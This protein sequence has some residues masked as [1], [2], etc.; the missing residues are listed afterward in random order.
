MKSSSRACIG[1]GGAGCEQ[2]P[3]GLWQ[4]ARLQTALLYPARPARQAPRTSTYHQHHQPA[5][6]IST[7]SKQHHNQQRRH[8]RQQQQGVTA[9]QR[10]FLKKKARSL[11]WPRRHWPSHHWFSRHTALPP[12]S[13]SLLAEKEARERKNKQQRPHMAEDA[14]VFIPLVQAAHRLGQRHKVHGAAGLVGQGLLDH[15][16]RQ[17]VGAHR[18][19]A[20][21]LGVGGDLQ[22]GWGWGWGGSGLESRGGVG[23]GRVDGRGGWA[24]QLGWVLWQGG[25]GASQ[26]RSLVVGCHSAGTGS[27][28]APASVSH[29]LWPSPLLPRNPG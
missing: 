8:Q 22:W 6:R 14:L 11:P 4:P 21:Q 2:L 1:V 19:E 26:L 29:L 5:S 17:R 3:Q 13:Q 28:L 15:T 24:T 10:E 20:P 27:Q 12:H 23:V 7:T 25:G 16:L 18:H 9:A